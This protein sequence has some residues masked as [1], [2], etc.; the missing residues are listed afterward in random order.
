MQ[1]LIKIQYNRKF[2]QWEALTAAGQ[3]GQKLQKF[4][5]DLNLFAATKEK[6]ITNAFEELRDDNPILVRSADWHPSAIH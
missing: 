3:N 4:G 2:Q 1:T 5:N 6:C